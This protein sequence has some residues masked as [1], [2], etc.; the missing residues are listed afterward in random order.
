MASEKCR[1]S[2]F[3]YCQVLLLCSLLIRTNEFGH[4][5]MQTHTRN[6]N[7][8]ATCM[9][10]QLTLCS[11]VVMPAGICV[12]MWV[13]AFIFK[14]SNSSVGFSLIYCSLRVSVHLWNKNVSLY[15]L[16]NALQ[17]V[18]TSSITEQIYYVCY[19][20][21]PSESPFRTCKLVID[22]QSSCQV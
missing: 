2:I 9:F 10:G 19:C 15:G 12:L 14:W 18:L 3:Q 7:T 11:C 1:N 8:K 5:A 16:Q 22:K 4:T 21:D 17:T 6:L 20:L 13:L